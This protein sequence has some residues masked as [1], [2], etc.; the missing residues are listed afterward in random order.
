M[1][2]VRKILQTKIQV[3]EKLNNKDL[4]IY[5]IVLFETRKKSTFSKNQELHN[6]KNN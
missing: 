6:F 3:L 1:S 5:Q 4:W 2:V